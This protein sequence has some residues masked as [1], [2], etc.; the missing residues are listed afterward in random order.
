M[1]KY[2]FSDAPWSVINIWS[3]MSFSA[4]SSQGQPLIKLQMSWNEEELIHTFNGIR[5]TT[6]SSLELLHSL[7]S[8]DARED[9]IL[10]VSYPKSGK[11][12]LEFG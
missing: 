11:V 8:F 12:C 6:R 7:V 2:V 1:H 5:F 10:L 9:D 3:A 4:V